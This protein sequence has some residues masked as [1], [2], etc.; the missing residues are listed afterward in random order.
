MTINALALLM[1]E[2]AQ[3]RARI[4]E[5]EAD[6]A[7]T[8]AL[9]EH[10]LADMQIVIDAA[11]ARISELETELAESDRMRIDF[12]NGLTRAETRLAAV[13]ALCDSDELCWEQQPCSHPVHQCYAAVVRAAAT[14]DPS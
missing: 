5:L 7:A 4:A 3:L 1:S 8:R 6:R 13:I 2:N 11:R 9:Y 14:G 12:T 10:G